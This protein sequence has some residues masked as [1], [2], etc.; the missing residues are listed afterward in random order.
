M[1]GKGSTCKPKLLF[2]R[3][4]RSRYALATGSKARAGHIEHEDI[5]SFLLV[6]K[7][8]M[9]ARVRKSKSEEKVVVCCLRG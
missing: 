1:F 9:A 3:L 8:E 4:L 5:Q 2:L 6:L 7:L